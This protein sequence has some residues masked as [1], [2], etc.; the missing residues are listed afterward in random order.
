MKVTLIKV[1]MFDDKNYDAM[2]PLVFAVFDKITPKDIQIEYIDE[3]VEDLPSVINS[4]VIALSVDTYA[5]R[6]A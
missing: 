6:R 1:R 5:T 4:D 3:R 2:K